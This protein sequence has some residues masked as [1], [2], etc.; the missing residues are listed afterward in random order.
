MKQILL[1]LA[2]AYAPLAMASPFLFVSSPVMASITTLG[3]TTAL[4]AI[5]SETL[6]VAKAG[7]LVAAE[8]RITDFETAW[9]AAQDK[10][11]PMD[12]AAWTTV[13]HAADGAIEALR[14][15]PASAEVAVPAIEQL[16]AVLGSPSAPAAGAV[17]TPTAFSMTNADGS[18]VPCEVALEEVRKV[19]ATKTLAGAAKAKFEELQTKG[20]ER[21]NADDDKRADGFFGDALTILNM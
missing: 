2:V 17:V 6:T 4:Q 9:D 10:M 13:D 18:P 5:A 3:D 8:K 20:I 19:A 12:T 11:R 7:D 14:A 15:S 1:A 16:V 21:C